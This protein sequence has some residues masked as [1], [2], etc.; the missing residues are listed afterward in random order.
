MIGPDFPTFPEAGIRFL[1]RLKRNNNRNWF[2]TH[3]TEYEECI[4]KPMEELICAL[5]IEFEN[6]APEIEASP[7]VSLYRI[8]R[9]TRFSKNKQP[10]KTH[11]AAV[12]PTRDLGKHEG[13]GFYFHISPNEFLIG[14][15]LYMPQPEHL[16][17]IRNQIAENPVGLEKIVGNSRFRK[18][19]GELTG[20]SLT[21]V[22]RGFSPDHRAATYLRMK[23]YLATRRLSPEAITSPGLRTILLETFIA[24][25]PLLRFLNEPIRRQKRIRDRETFVLR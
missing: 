24:G 4:K 16:R 2:Q 15:G 17:A 7:R 9:D 20:D 13:A 5:A 11:A 18:T 21:R 1:R 14:G 25:L 3:K 10:Y 6:I 12:F 22:P 19:F 23:Q 8:Y